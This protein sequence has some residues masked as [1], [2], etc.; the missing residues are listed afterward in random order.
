MVLRRKALF[1]NNHLM[2]ISKTFLLACAIC[3]A[4]FFVRGADTEAQ[5]KA[6]EALQK[7]MYGTE[8]SG[9]QATEAAKPKV[10]PAAAQTAPAIAPAGDP[11][12]VAKA[13]EAMRQKLQE[14]GGGPPPSPVPAPAVAPVRA[15]VPAA[16][17]A[18]IAQPAVASTPASSPAADSDALARA[19]EAMRQKLQEFGAAPAAPVAP[20]SAAPAPVAPGPAAVAPVLA[21]Q[22][23]PSATTAPA[24]ADALAKAREAMRRKLQEVEGQAAPAPAPAA[25]AVTPAAPAQTAPVTTAPAPAVAAAPAAAAPTANE[26]ALAKAREAMRQKLQQVEGLPPT[27]PVAA[28]PRLPAQPATTTTA[29]APVPPP[30]PAAQPELDPQVIAKA[31]EAVRQKLNEIEAQPAAQQSQLAGQPS[32]PSA[33]SPSVAESKPPRKLVRPATFQSK[34]NFPALQGPPVNLTPEKQQQLNVLL[35]KYK[36]DE[37]TPEQ[38]HAERARII[39]VQ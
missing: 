2:Q 29:A 25:V 18:P 38:Y 22:P 13:R 28:A 23:A 26:E 9:S 5:I 36:A 12:A 34:L 19:R 32:K 14:L 1:G 15:A 3:G 4:F 35:E 11:A 17:P 33:Q 39:G 27:A 21:T 31:R 6:R 16:A 8:A 10:T 30:Q 24:E 37:L 7:K 20:A